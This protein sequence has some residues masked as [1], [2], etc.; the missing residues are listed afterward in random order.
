[1]TSPDLDAFFQ[2]ILP[3]FLINSQGID[4]PQRL[5]L[6]NNFSSDT[7]SYESLMN[8]IPVFSFLIIF[9]LLRIAQD[10]PSFTQNTHRLTY[11][12]RCFRIANASRASLFQSWYPLSRLSAFFPLLPPPADGRI[13]FQSCCSLDY[14]VRRAGPR[15]AVI[16]ASSWN[17]NEHCARNKWKKRNG[18]VSSESH[19]MNAIFRRFP[20]CQWSFFLFWS[21]FLKVNEEKKIKIDYNGFCLLFCLPLSISVKPMMQQKK[22]NRKNFLSYRMKK[23]FFCISIWGLYKAKMNDLI[24][25]SPVCRLIYRCLRRQMEINIRSGGKMLIER[26]GLKV[27]EIRSVS[28]LFRS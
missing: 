25:I 27:R 24:Q 3:N 8:V 9:N 6:K 21:D 15:G 28:L 23:S 10:L 5:A 13:A 11:D 20:A 2:T 14:W 17:L 19:S 26:L 12:L 4:D 18:L 7:V 1:M 16:D 22:Y